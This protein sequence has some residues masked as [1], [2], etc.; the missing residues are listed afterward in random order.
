MITQQEARKRAMQ[1][2]LQ[3][4]NVENDEPFIFDESTIEKDFGW[5]FFYDSRRFIETEE[6]S[7][8]L[9]GN[10]PIIVNRFDGS[11]HFTGTAYDT[12][13]YITEYEKN[14]K[15]CL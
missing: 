7:Y 6:F 3:N 4:W 12:E 14:L 8:C 13:Q 5:V 9:A 15:S 11:A 2:I 1:K 10:A